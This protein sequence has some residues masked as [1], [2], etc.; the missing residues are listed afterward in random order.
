MQRFEPL[1]ARLAKALDDAG[2]PYMVIGGLAVV[3]QGKLRLTKD[4]DL[5]LD[6]SP[7][8]YEKL[9]PVLKNAGIVPRVT[10]A[11]ER[12]RHSCVLLCIDEKTKIAV[13]MSLGDSEYVREAIGRAKRFRRAGKMVRIATAEDLL[14]HKIIASRP[15]DFQDIEGIL[16]RQ[17]KLDWKYMEH[18]LRLFG[19]ALERPL[20]EELLKIRRELE[21]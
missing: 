18:W 7:F 15:Q 10:D 6:L 4:V 12:V 2:I 11:I 13:D 5:T 14:I 3:V 8:D 20:W 16:L 9:L 21:V 17:R 19:E 1:Q